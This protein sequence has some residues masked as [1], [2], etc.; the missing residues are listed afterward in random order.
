M[1]ENE[2]CTERSKEILSEL[3]QMPL[4]AYTD[5]ICDTL[6]DYRRHHPVNWKNLKRFM[7]GEIPCPLQIAE[8]D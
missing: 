8:E 4:D 3:K 5:F 7:D 1:S 2:K 6:I